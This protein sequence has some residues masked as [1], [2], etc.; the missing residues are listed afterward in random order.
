MSLTKEQNDK[1]FMKSIKTPFSF[2][3]KQ[4]IDPPELLDPNAMYT[5]GSSQNF[6]IVDPAWEE[7]KEKRR[8]ILGNDPNSRPPRYRS[9]EK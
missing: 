8:N 7:I 6:E 9:I 1:P 3:Q 4:K 5:L 2:A